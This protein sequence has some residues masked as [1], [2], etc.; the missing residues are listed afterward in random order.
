MTANMN[1]WAAAEEARGGGNRVTSKVL[2]WHKLRKVVK[3]NKVEVLGIQGHDYKQEKGESR[4]KA[5]LRLQEATKRFKWI[6][7]ESETLADTPR[8]GLATFWNK[9]KFQF[10]GVHEISNRILVTIL[11][12]DDGVSW[13]FV[14]VHFHNDAG[15]RRLQWELIMS[16]I[17]R[18][19]RATW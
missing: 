1:G 13:T 12:D 3:Y 6:E 19:R 2:R 14:N 5:M 16:S 18:Y 4:E 9:E 11:R 15:P 8:L 7:W 17:Q 10:V